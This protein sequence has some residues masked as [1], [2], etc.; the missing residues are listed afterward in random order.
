MHSLKIINMTE[1]GIVDKGN[2]C[3]II[4]VKKDC[5]IKIGAKGMIDFKEGYYVY[6]GSA[7]GTLSNR[8]KR[9]L[10]DDKK[11]HW[12][13]DYLLLNKNTKIKQVIY[14]YCTEKIECD[15]S[16]NINK[17]SNE[18]IESFGCS[19]CKC[20]SHL[21]YFNSFQSAIN[22]SINSYKKINYK[23]YKWFD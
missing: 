6:V 3:L 17:D 16:K 15:I 21:Y 19:D 14:T 5:S 11:K 12:H 1:E 13:A 23:P 10:S 2:Y 18:Y 9:H 8:I 4:H 22:S 20:M 7:L